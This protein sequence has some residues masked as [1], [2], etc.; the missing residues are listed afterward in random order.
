MVTRFS[1][2][3]GDDRSTAPPRDFRRRQL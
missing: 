2:A 3:V 1:T